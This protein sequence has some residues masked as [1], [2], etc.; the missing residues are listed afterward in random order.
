MPHR[1]QELWV[2]HKE[3]QGGHSVHIRG[4]SLAKRNPLILSQVTQE[5][6]LGRVAGYAVKG[7][8]GPQAEQQCSVVKG[9]AKAYTLCFNVQQSGGGGEA[10]YKQLTGYCCVSRA[11]QHKPTHLL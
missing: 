11:P 10:T 7:L 9:L 3:R 4:H 6:K 8:V 2:G 1:V 5:P